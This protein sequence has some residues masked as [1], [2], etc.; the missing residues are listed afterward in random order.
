MKYTLTLSA[1]LA[2]NWLLWSGY[3]N[4]PFLLG[5]GAVSCIFCVYIARRMKIVDDEGAPVQLGIRPFT[6]YAPWLIKEIVVANLDVTRILLARKMPIQRCV[7]EVDAPQK[8]ELGRV[9]LAN[10]ITLTPGTVAIN[11]HGSQ[12]TVHALSLADAEEDIA[13]EMSDR[14]CDLEPPQS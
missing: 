1:A 4:H 5:V 8:T 13:G 12:I 11:L 7:V 2:A 10:S 6:R 14:I 3:F 9:I